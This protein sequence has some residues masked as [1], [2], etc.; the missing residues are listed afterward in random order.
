[1]PWSATPKLEALLT[2][3]LDV[4]ILRVTQEWSPVTRRDGA[5]G[6]CAWSPWSS[7]ERSMRTTRTFASLVDQPLAVF[8]DPVDSGSYNAYGEYLTALEQDLEITMTWLGTPGAFS[9]CLAHVRRADPPLGTW[10]SSPTPNA[11]P[12]PDSRLGGLESASRTTPG[13]SRGATTTRAARPSTSSRSRGRSQPSA[14]GSTL[15]RC[16]T[17]ATDGRAGPRR[18][19]RS[20]GGPGGSTSALPMNAIAGW[21]AGL[22]SARS[23]ACP[24]SGRCSRGPAESRIAGLPALLLWPC[25]RRPRSCS[26]A[27]TLPTPLTSIK[28]WASKRCSGLQW[29]ACRSMWT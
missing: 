7:W 2:N 9:H 24:C 29:T 19:T 3:R 1:M 12:P 28:R 20:Q 4:A 5:I 27:G 15:R 21:R 13:R 22:D 14:A 8:G 6:C 23:D 25:S 16:S 17:V 18:S 26:S 10:S 11:M